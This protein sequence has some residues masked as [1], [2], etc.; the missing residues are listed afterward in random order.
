M[1]CLI[2]CLFL[3]VAMPVFA[4]PET[5]LNSDRPVA[6]NNWQHQLG[7]DK[8]ESDTR[9][10][11]RDDAIFSSFMRK[12]ELEVGNVWHYPYAEDSKNTEEVGIKITFNM[13]GK[14]IKIQLLKSSGNKMLDEEVFR[15]LKVIRPIGGFP[16]GYNKDEFHMITFFGLAGPK[17]Y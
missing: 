8:F 17:S 9:F 14:I 3:F 11:Y 10:F 13:E 4:Q 12:F 5:H 2:A 15:S 6:N 1:K 7:Q 16:K